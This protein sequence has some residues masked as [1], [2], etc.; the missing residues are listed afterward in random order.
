MKKSMIFAAIISAAF[1]TF[2]CR[3]F[4]VVYEESAS[5]IKRIALLELKINGC[6]AQG[7]VFALKG[8]SVNLER[9]FLAFNA[10]DEYIFQERKECFMLFCKG[11]VRRLGLLMRNEYGATAVC[12]DS[13]GNISGQADAPLPSET[14]GL[15]PPPGAK[16]ILSLQPGSGKNGTLQV[17]YSAENGITPLLEHF[18]SQFRANGW[19]VSWSRHAGLEQGS[20]IGSR[21]AEWCFVSFSPGI[22]VFSYGR[23]G[24]QNEK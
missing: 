11:S 22:C 19:T 23:E 5:S 17:I 24:R 16:C 3:V 4:P 7:Y 6:P 14:G 21:G 10:A 1:F 9:S 12:L 18:N 15:E 20:I 2:P 13:P 8:A